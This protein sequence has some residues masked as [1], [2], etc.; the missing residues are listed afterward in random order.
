VTA[1]LFASDHTWLGAPVFVHPLCITISFSGD[2]AQSTKCKQDEAGAPHGIRCGPFETTVDV[3][4]VDFQCD[5]AD[6]IS[7]HGLNKSSCDA[8][9]FVICS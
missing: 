6:M 5:L 1:R 8:A 4:D 3:T 2:Q 7:K 9:N